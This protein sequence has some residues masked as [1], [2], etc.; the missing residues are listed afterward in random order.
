[1][2][3]AVPRP[4]WIERNLEAPVIP[5]YTRRAWAKI[6]I[7][8]LVARYGW[9]REVD[10]AVA[11]QGVPSLKYL[12]PDQLDQVLAQL[13]SLEECLQTPCDPPDSPPAR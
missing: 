2:R 3:D 11:R 1:M 7:Q 9:Q 10:R 6:E 5:V 4:H 12:S 8:D 13:R